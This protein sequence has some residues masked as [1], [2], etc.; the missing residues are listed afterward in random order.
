MQ[1]SYFSAFSKK[2]CHILLTITCLGTLF[3]IEIV[4]II[5]LL[6]NTFLSQEYLKMLK[7][8]IVQRYYANSAL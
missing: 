3:D 8:E 7:N 5:M 6:K 4:M 2:D 1:L